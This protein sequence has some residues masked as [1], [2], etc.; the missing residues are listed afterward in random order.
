MR[1]G[2]LECVTGMGFHPSLLSFTYLARV[3]F[4]DDFQPGASRL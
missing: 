2:P 1:I 3:I 4:F